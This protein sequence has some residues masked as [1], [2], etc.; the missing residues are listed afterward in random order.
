VSARRV[1]V[2]K[3]RF[4]RIPVAAVAP[5]A[6]AQA[7]G[8][9]ATGAQPTG[10]QPT[11]VQTTGVQ[12]IVI[13]AKS[14]QPGRSKTRLTPTFTPAESA[15]LA[16]AALHDTI[17]AASAAAGS[18]ASSLVLAWDGPAV[19][20]W[21]VGAVVQQQ[22]GDGL[23][24]RLEHAFADAFRM[25]PD[26]PVLLIGMDTPQLEPADLRVGWESTDDDA[27]ADH[28]AADADAVL[29]LSPDGGFWAVG[30]RR[31]VVGAFLGV[32]MSTQRTG[33][34][35]LERL[36]SLGL[37]VRLLPAR[38]DVD[39]P[40][41]AQAVAA[42]APDTRFG[43]LH[44]RLVGAPCEPSTL[45]DAAL[46]G[47]QVTVHD[48][49]TSTTSLLRAQDWVMMSGADD[50]LVSR[51]EPPVLDIGC[52]P[53]RLVEALASRGVAALGVDVSRAAVAHT[54][55]RGCAVLRRNVSGR[56]PAE[57]RWATVLLADGNI[58]I[59]G[60]PHALLMR[61]RDLL[62]SGGLA[63]VEADPDAHH[64]ALTSLTLHGP[65]GRSSAPF[66]WARVG[67]AGLVAIA[68]ECGFLAVEE[69]RVDGRVFVA[70]RQTA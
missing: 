36:R 41:D 34:Q 20:W 26:T 67:A 57:G 18:C 55:A 45:F 10:A 53:G 31:P 62:R 61:C 5:T 11:G 1:I 4:D 13:L 43:R 32:P 16:A 63:V 50:V 23:D 70:L 59:G 69:W 24:E 2:L 12:T 29:G 15:A 28:A 35:Q 33:I 3:R 48:A 38:R 37:R 8:A 14:P 9:Q 27:A 49:R 54:A 6:A 42:I 52:G 66:A 40:A 25:R 21:P 58:G 17:D 56:L 44:R 39:T 46:S 68:A 64:T 19:P 30:L 22:R 47:Q 60:D 7:T 65:T 51:C